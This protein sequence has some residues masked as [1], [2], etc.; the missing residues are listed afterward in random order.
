LRSTDCASH[1]QAA[2]E[3]IPRDNG[4]FTSGNVTSA[5]LH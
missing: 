1:V 2:A 3:T 4:S 5:S